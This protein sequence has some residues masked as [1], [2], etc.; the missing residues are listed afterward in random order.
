MKKLIHFDKNSKINVKSY[1]LIKNGKIKEYRGINIVGNLYFKTP[2]KNVI[3][4]LDETFE[5]FFI[6][7]FERK[8]TETAGNYELI[9]HSIS[10]NF[11]DR[12]IYLKLNFIEKFI[13]DYSK[14][15]SV[16]HEMKFKQKLIYAIIFIFI[17]FIF[18]F[19]WNYF[20]NNN[21]KTSQS[22]RPNPDFITNN[23]DTIIPTIKATI[24]SDK[25]IKF[26][27]D[28]IQSLQ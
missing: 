17:P 11:A 12:K 26:E 21:S 15:Q 6:S 27:R 28:S 23:Q 4:E 10:K 3:E 5:L 22:Q 1:V 18:M 8:R 2:V 20:T 7:K 25:T 24:V 19:L 9:C 13:I 14:E 16:F